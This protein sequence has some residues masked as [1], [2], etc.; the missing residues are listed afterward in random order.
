DWFPNPL[1]PSS[2]I[3]GKKDLGGV[4]GTLGGVLGGHPGSAGGTPPVVLGEHPG[5]AGGHPKII[6]L[7]IIQLKSIHSRTRPWQRHPRPPPMKVCVRKK[8]LI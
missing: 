6:Q 4:G 3:R 5:S 1:K 2:L 8:N 7:K